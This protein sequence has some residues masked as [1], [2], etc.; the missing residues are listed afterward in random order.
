MP[1][2]GFEPTIPASARPQTYALDRADTGIGTKCV[3]VVCGQNSELFSSKPCGIVQTIGF[4]VLVN[5]NESRIMYFR[6]SRYVGVFILSE[7]YVP[8]E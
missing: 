2:V 7:V 3:D 6:V 8:R 5:S 1:P 4:K